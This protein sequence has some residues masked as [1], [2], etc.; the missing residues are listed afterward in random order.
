[1]AYSAHCFVLLLRSLFSFL[2][3]V[4]FLLSIFHYEF[5]FTLFNHSAHLWVRTSTYSYVQT[6]HVSLRLLYYLSVDSSQFV[7]LSL[8]FGKCRSVCLSV[9]IP[10]IPRRDS[11]QVFN[12]GSLAV[13]PR[14]HRVPLALTQTLGLSQARPP[15]V[16]CVLTSHV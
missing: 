9:R 2:F 13:D 8:Y 11:R 14:R 4:L 12:F 1:M 10:S 15:A 16:P 3:G 5:H 7:K 6:M